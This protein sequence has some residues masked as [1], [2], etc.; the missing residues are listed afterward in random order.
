MFEICQIK[1]L[2]EY[3]CLYFSTNEKRSAKY[4]N[5]FPIIISMIV[6][7][8]YFKIIN[9]FALDFNNN[10][11]IWKITVPVLRFE[12]IFVKI[13]IYEII[14]AA[15]VTPVSSYI[16]IHFPR[17]SLLPSLNFISLRVLPY[18]VLTTFNYRCELIRA[19]N[20][21]CLC[22]NKNKRRRKKWKGRARGMR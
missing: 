6:S 8:S 9:G 21:R 11:K 7:F 1:L 22:A 19:R 16:H 17:D 4:F 13:T 3:K 2:Y 12:P 15:L 14:K 10:R 20:T 5:T 18:R